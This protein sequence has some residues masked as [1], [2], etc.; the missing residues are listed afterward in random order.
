MPG[1]V[2]QWFS[3]LVGEEKAAGGQQ[4]PQMLCIALEQGREDL[5]SRELRAAGRPCFVILDLEG[6]VGDPSVGVGGASVV[7]DQVCVGHSSRALVVGEQE[8]ASQ[9]DGNYPDIL[10]GHW[11]HL[12]RVSDEGVEQLV[13]GMSSTATDCLSL[14]M[15]CQ[16]IPVQSLDE[17]HTYR[18]ELGSLVPIHGLSMDGRIPCGKVFREYIVSPTIHGLSMDGRIPCGKVFREYIVSP[19]IHGLSMDVIN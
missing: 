11:P 6:P 10:E 17:A 2:I 18:H 12:L 4:W 3:R 19:T 8:A 16:S 1:Q 5:A 7:L 9:P 14:S 13:G 15:D